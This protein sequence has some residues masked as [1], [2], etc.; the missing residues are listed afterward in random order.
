[1]TGDSELREFL[2]ELTSGPIKRPYKEHERIIS[3]RPD[4]SIQVV[5]LGN[6]RYVRT[7][8][9]NCHADSFGLTT[10]EEF[11]ALQET[12]IEGWADS[13]FVALMLPTLQPNANPNLEHL[14]VYFD[15][16]HHILHSGIGVGDRVVSK[17]GDGNTYLHSLYETPA[18]YGSSVRRYQRPP[19][20][21]ALR[22]YLDW[23]A[24]L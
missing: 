15:E 12:N 11:W 17:W 16:G 14:V 1:M 19:V 7:W 3:E 5:Q 6:P 24:T 4:H 13:R 10:R 21:T 20:D 22:T 23:A 2:K 9:F 8:R 18:S